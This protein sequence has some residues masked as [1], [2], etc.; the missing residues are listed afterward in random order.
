MS[1]KIYFIVNARMSSRQQASFARAILRHLADI[2]HEIHTTQYPGH[3]SEL[4]QTFLN[5][6]PAAIVAVG[7]D[8]TINEIIQHTIHTGIPVGVIPTGSGNGFAR[9]LSI[10][11]HIEKA[12]SVV[13][14]MHIRQV[15][16]GKINER[17]FISNAGIGLDAAVCQQI[18]QTE[19]RGLKMYVW[20][21]TKVF[22]RY[23]PQ[24]YT[25]QTPHNTIT[26][27]AHL[28]NIANGSQMGYGFKIAPKAMIDDGL[29]E[30]NI[31][32]AI[33]VFKSSIV[34]LQ[35]WLG[36]LADNKQII[37][38]QTNQALISN[39]TMQYFQAD[40]DAYACNGNCEISVLKQAQSF[41][42]PK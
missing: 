32:P 14:D 1:K 21:T 36:Q 35:G 26:T 28:I 22:S 42:T 39:P 6:E 9:H 17:Y 40:G 13:M 30:L 16:V 31:I 37:H 34:V 20:A 10:P 38:H 18:K 4:T 19:H 25:I 24:Y 3:T 5:Q 8:G 33:N 11:L 2:P 12:L 29:L 15:D 23:K 27:S 7:G 41:I